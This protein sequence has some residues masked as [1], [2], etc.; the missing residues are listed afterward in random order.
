VAILDK[1]QKIININE[2]FTE[3]F[4]YSLSEAEGQPIHR[5]I[6]SPEGRVDI[7][8]NIESAYEGKVVK[9]EGLRKGK[10]GKFIEVEILVYPVVY[11]DVVVGLYSIYIDITDKKS[12]EKQLLLFRKI[13]EN[14]SE[15][16]VITDINGDVQWINNAFTE[17]TG[18]SLKDILGKKTN[19]LKSRV[20]DQEF[21]KEMWSKLLS[22]GKWSGEIWNKNKQGDTYCEW[23]TISDIKNEYAETTHYVGIFKDLSEKKSID[24]RMSELQKKDLLT[25]L[26]NRNYFLKILDRCIHEYIKTKEDFAIIAID[27]EAFKE[28][29][30]SLGHLVGDKL[31]I[32]I[33]KR[34]SSFISNKCFVSR[35]DGDEFMV[36]YNSVTEKDIKYFTEKLLEKINLPYK[37]E[38]TVIYLNVKIGVSKF[39]ENAMNGESL[40]RYANIAMYKAKSEVKESVCFYSKEMSE[41]IEKKFY[42]ANYLVEAI[43]NEELA[44]HYQPIFDIKEQ[45]IVGAEALLRWNSTILGNV[46]P[47]KFIPLAE[48]TGLILPIGQW[49]LNDVCRQINKWKHNGYNLIPIAINISVKQ[50]QQ[51]EFAQMV[52]NIIKENNINSKDIELEITESVSSGDI[53]IIAKNLKELKL[54]GIKISMDDFGTG[55]SSLGQLD[56]FELDKLKIDK[57][58]IDEL[59]NVSRK[60]SLVKSIIAMAGSLDLLVVAEGIETEDQLNYLK[61][62]NCQLGQGY[63]FSKPLPVEKIE[64]FLVK[65]T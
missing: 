40:I 17:I 32:E 58:F 52:L 14:N 34:I 47:D 37:I 13:L 62:I 35:F 4:Q 29:N 57:I 59:V 20:H 12:Y 44:V 16:A 11:H 10:Y 60:Q 43:D 8:E 54:N 65:V 21:Y 56:L 5:L 63:L 7:D 36:L 31:L 30:D 15:G 51:P 64:K 25:G 6:S 24:I 26:Y 61:K 3:L 45:S 2:T 48:K 23:L 50:L 53:T 18:Y 41:E 38:K 19:V 46:P 39:P 28:I 42:L 27:I 9:Q 33:S 22:K 55:F 49:V 1:E